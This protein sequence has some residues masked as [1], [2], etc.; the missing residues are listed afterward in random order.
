MGG[1]TGKPDVCPQ[2]TAGAT[3]RLVCVFS[4]P[5]LGVGFTVGWLGPS[6]LLAHCQACAALMR[7]GI[8]AK[9]DPQG[10]EAGRADLA[11]FAMGDP[12]QEG[13]CSTRREA[14]PLE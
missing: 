14:D 3:L 4:S 5:V 12:L 11:R 1:A 9:V 2:P 7:S 10:A 13:P 6:G 8:L